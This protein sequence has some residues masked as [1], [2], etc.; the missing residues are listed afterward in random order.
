MA[1][2]FAGG[3]LC[4]A[5]RY[6]CLAE[7]VMSANCYCRDC[8]RST[9][10]A[11]A[12]LLIVP[13]AAFK[14]TKGNLRYFEVTAESGNKVRRGFCADCGSPVASL[15]SDMPNVVVIKAASLDDPSWFR[16]TASIFVSSA[17]PWAPVSA[18]LA[19]FEKMP[20]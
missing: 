10:S 8:Q 19:R 1:S 15:L 14:F 18:G 5:V 2:S 17:Q 16:P 12:P 7:P 3:C 9:G 20:G 11:M 13:K 4:E 6:E